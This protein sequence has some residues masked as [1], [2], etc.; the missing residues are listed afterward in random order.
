M[1]IFSQFLQNIL[2]LLEEVHKVCGSQA[3]PRQEAGVEAGVTR[4]LDTWALGSAWCRH[5]NSLSLTAP[6]SRTATTTIN[7]GHPDYLG[8]ERQYLATYRKRKSC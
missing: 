7:N 3:E 5:S 6:L 2:S 1:P 8:V 4:D